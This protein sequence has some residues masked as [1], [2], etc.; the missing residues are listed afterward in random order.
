MPSSMESQKRSKYDRL[1]PDPLAMGEDTLDAAEPFWRT[2]RLED[3]SAEEWESL[4]DG[5]GRCCLNKIEDEDTGEIHLT[6]LAC[7]MLDLG[8]CKCSDY[9]NRRDKMPDCVQITPE[10]ARALPWLP[11][12]CAYRLVGEGRDLAWW[13]PLVSGTQSTVHEAGIS[14]RGWARSEARIKLESYWRYII[15]DYGPR[16]AAPGRGPADGSAP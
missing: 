10:K 12:T 2:K 13:H 3:M 1:A 5:C 4:C 6:R 14:V 15:P 9:A 8:T 11:P 16:G 7:R